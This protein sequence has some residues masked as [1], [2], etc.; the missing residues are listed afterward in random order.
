MLNIIQFISQ[1]DMSE[2]H[3]NIED[4]SI[5]SID[6][7]NYESELPSNLKRKKTV[8]HEQKIN[9]V[10]LIGIILILFGVIYA[11]ISFN[12]LKN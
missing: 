2:S 4:V 7:D 12:K 9:L 1:K 6:A 5:A 11:F 3:R 10:K 8:K